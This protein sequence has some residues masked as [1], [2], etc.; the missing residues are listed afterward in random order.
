MPPFV[1][2]LNGASSAGKTSIA[3]ALQRLAPT[4]VL[5]ASLDTFTDMFHW[6][7]IL[8]PERRRECHRAAVTSFHVALPQLAAGGFSVVVDHVFE[9]P[10][11]FEACRD[12]LRDHSPVWVGVHCPLTVLETREA[13]RGDRRIG[14]A[15]WQSGRV[16]LAPTYALSL[17]TSVLT[18][19]ECARRLLDHLAR[20]HPPGHA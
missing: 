17:D 12:A 13:A 6:P 20:P 5:H 19:D 14:L 1:L 7:A 4:P 15:R 9:Q 10:A 8:D 3:R 2:V 18:P 16:H 11:W